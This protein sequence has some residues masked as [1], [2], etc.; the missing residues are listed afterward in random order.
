MVASSTIGAG[1]G[2]EVT[3]GGLDRTER[4]R[5]AIQNQIVLNGDE[6]GGGGV[7]QRFAPAVA[8]FVAQRRTDRRR[9]LG[10]AA[11]VGRRAIVGHS[12]KSDAHFRP[13]ARDRRSRVGRHRNGLRSCQT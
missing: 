7:H 8:G 6:T 3:Y 13:R 2:Q 9:S 4:V 5:R 10:R 12:E 1:P 11:Q